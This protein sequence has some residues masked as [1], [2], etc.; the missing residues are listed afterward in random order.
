MRA[1]WPSSSSRPG[2]WPIARELEARA[3]A[4]AARYVE[5]RKARDEIKTALTVLEPRSAGAGVDGAVA[6]VC[7]P[8][9]AARAAQANVLR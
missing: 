2:M 6:A 3:S 8:L 7:G 5:C 1:N 4:E 9:G